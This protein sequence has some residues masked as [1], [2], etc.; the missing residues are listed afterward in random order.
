M[1]QVNFQNLSAKRNEKVNQSKMY[2]ELTL[3]DSA[4]HKSRLIGAVSN[5][6]GKS[7]KCERGSVFSEHILNTSVALF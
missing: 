1:L 4:M 6:E 2:F 5:G 3:K 7:S